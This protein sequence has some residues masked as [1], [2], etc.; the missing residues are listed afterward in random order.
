MRWEEYEEALADLNE[1]ER[2]LAEIKARIADLDSR[3]WLWED[4]Y[5]EITLEDEATLPV[6]LID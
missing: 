4:T 2:S 6:V 1:I 3:E 5:S